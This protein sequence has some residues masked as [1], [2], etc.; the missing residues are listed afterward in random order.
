VKL[1]V[2]IDALDR[3][4]QADYE[5]RTEVNR[6][7]KA[8]EEQI[9]GLEASRVKDR[10]NERVNVV[11][12][13]N[14]I[15]T[16]RENYRAIQ[17]ATKRVESADDAVLT[18]EQGV[19]QAEA[20]LQQAKDDLA[21]LTIAQEEAK[22]ALAALAPVDI[23]AGKAMQERLEKSQEINRQV[24]MAEALEVSIT[25]KRGAV[26]KETAESEKLT[27]ALEDRKQEKMAAIA[28]AKMPIEG[29]SL[30][31]GRVLF[32]DIPLDQ[33]SSAEQLR[34][35]TAIAMSSNP[36]LRVIRIKDGSLLDPDGMDML[37]SMAKENDFQICFCRHRQDA[38]EPAVE[39]YRQGSP[40][41]ANDRT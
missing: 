39:P 31:G 4:N 29:L 21:K 12:L 3:Q 9:K 14:E 6:R 36:E 30:E 17:D 27:L 41:A 2:D 24:D 15:N 40:A 33:A 1:D 7:V 37:K 20:R 10:P 18:G 13:S 28:A 5:R 38:G 35:S 16:L 34:V 8:L 22:K 26:T 11:G 32:N 19:Q 25:E 23:E